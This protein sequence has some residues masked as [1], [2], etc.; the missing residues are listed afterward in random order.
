MMYP[1]VHIIY[2]VFTNQTNVRV[3]HHRRRGSVSRSLGNSAHSV[4]LKAG[5]LAKDTYVR[6]LNVATT[7]PRR[8]VKM[9]TFMAHK[10]GILLKKSHTYT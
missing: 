6:V 9:Y 3:L 2:H 8:I 4:R 1:F 10:P 7:F 5:N